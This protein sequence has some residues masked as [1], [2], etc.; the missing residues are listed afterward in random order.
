VAAAAGCW[1]SGVVN[2]EALEWFPLVVLLAGFPLVIWAGFGLASDT[3]A[4]WRYGIEKTARV[5]ELDH[6]SSV[7]KG[8]TTFRCLRIP[9]T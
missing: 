2:E 1:D 6:T 5:V 9:T 8:G 4:F 3:Y 7:T